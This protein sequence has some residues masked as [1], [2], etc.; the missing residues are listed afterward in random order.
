ML[1]LLLALLLL[2]LLLARLL[3]LLHL[4]LVVVVVVMMQRGT[5]TR[6]VGV[7]VAPGTAP[8]TDAGIIGVAGPARAGV[9]VLALARLNK[10]DNGIAPASAHLDPVTTAFAGAGVLARAVRL[11]HTR[12]SGTP[13]QRAQTRDPQ[14]E[15]H[16]ESQ[17]R[18]ADHRQ[19]ARGP[20]LRDPIKHNCAIRVAEPPTGRFVGDHP[21]PNQKK[22]CG[23]GEPAHHM[24]AY[25]F[26]H[27][28]GNI[29]IYTYMKYIITRGC[30]I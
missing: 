14:R 15:R 20:A 24:G 21:G 12:Q 17:R 2:A 30:H 16:D 25:N 10:A 7:N 13:Q 29:Y 5:A 6:A 3:L 26:G 18:R 1:A 23:G 4:V 28:Y 22:P 8:G 19:M 9:V 11:R 27:R